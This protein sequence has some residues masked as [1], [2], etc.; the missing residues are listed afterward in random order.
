[1]GPSFVETLSV[2]RFHG[3]GPATAAKMN[4]LGIFTAIDLKAKD[5]SFLKSNFG[6]AGP[7]FYSICRGIDHRPVRADHIR[8]SIGAE[9]TFPRD[10][11]C[12]DEMRAELEPLVDKIWRYCESTGTRART[13]TLKLKFDDFQVITRS[14]SSIIAI[15]DRAR[16]ASIS[17]KLLDAQFP[18]SKKVR[19]VGVSLSSLSAVSE[20]D[21]RQM[22][23][24]L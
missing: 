1:M 12:L 24:R 10:L 15:S 13:V 23:L 9:S 11:T 21:D 17:T 6:K 3:V 2:E 5:E 19:L 14:R 7:H 8:K 16:L 20:D 4:H 22:A 18:L